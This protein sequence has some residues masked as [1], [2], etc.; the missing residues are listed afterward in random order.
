MRKPYFPAVDGTP[1]PLTLRV[2]RE[3]R[4]EEVDAVGIVWHGRY[5]SYFEDARVALGYRFGLGYMD[6][7]AQGVVAPIKTLHID[8]LRPLR[9]RE[10]FTIEGLWHW[11]EAARLNFEFILRNSA[12][13]I[14]TRGYSV[15]ML[16]DRNH[17]IL[18]VPPPFYR[19]FLQRWKN[20]ELV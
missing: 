18:V 11:N 14:T 5:P 4:F 20:G 6:F 15:Q 7:Y 2:E 13:E 17:E 1:P 8:H 16:L 9:F 19:D 10:S 12:D 3:V